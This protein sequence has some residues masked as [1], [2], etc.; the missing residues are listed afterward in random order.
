VGDGR[1]DRVLGGIETIRDIDVVNGAGRSPGRAGALVQNAHPG[2]LF[3]LMPGGWHELCIVACRRRDGRRQAS[4]PANLTATG[5]RHCRAPR[6]FLA[7]ARYKGAMDLDRLRAR[8]D[9][10]DSL[11][12]RIAHARDTLP[13]STLALATRSELPPS[14]AAV[15]FPRDEDEVAAC[16]AW[17]GEEGVAVVPYGA[18]SGVG[19]AASGMAGSLVLDTKRMD[20]V[21]AVEGDT[22]RVQPGVLGQHLEDVLEVH[23]RATR[24]SPS[25]IWCSTV[26]A[27]AAGRSAGQFSSAYG[28]FEDMVLATRVVAPAGRY[29]TGQWADGEDLHPWVLGTEGQLGV[30]TELLVRTVPLPT[31]RRLTGWR[32]PSVEAAW[33]AMRGLLQADLRPAVLRLYDPVDTRLA[34]R[35]TATRHTSSAGRWLAGL[36]TAVES[37]PGMRQHLLALPLALPR[38]VNRLA[39]NVASGTVLIAGWEGADAGEVARRA[40][41]GERLLATL[42]ESLGAEPGEHWYAHRHEVS[43]K[44]AP[45]F[46]H[47]GFADTMEVASTWSRL[48]AL[49]AGVRA[50]LAKHALVMA[51][52]SHAYREGCSIYFTFV[53]TGSLDVYDAAWRDALAAASAAGGTVAHHHGVGPLKM[54]AAARELA[55]ALPRFRELKARL[56]PKGL[57][58]PGR[59]FPDVEVPEPPVPEPSVDAVSRCATLP[60]QAP[61]AERDAWLAARGWALRFPTDGP[62][63]RALGRPREPWETTVLGACVRT[64][65]GR[66]VFVDVP[67]SSA[68][69][70][71]REAFP[72]DAYETLTVPVDPIA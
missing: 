72:P 15:A 22:V 32:F 44:M 16:L 3:G 37:V 69:P 19:G 5:A 13:R 28:K 14:P 27:W 67:R 31:A 18:G 38:L 68:G 42:G 11:R 60:A 12:E 59:L 48:P 20:R 47:G 26:G 41:E 24:H 61:A 9:V 63:A 64:P 25:S 21:L 62:L 57:L 2:L 45:V 58:N 50:A 7:P 51:H 36:R 33:E 40:E 54:H 52:F 10:D 8:V 1:R 43:Y 4:S 30:I 56:D 49:Y 6:F 29:A 17:A 71:P 35:G 34:G 53:G 66:A 23:G 70:D 65:Q 55:G 39:E 46:A